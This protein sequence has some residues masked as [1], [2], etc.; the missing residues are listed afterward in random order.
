MLL[1]CLSVS[2]GRPH[3][4][5]GHIDFVP[6]VFPTAY[7]KTRKDEQSEKRYNRVKKRRF[8][9][10]LNPEAEETHKKGE[11]GEAGC[12]RTMEKEVMGATNIEASEENERGTQTCVSG[13]DL[14]D[15]ERE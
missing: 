3:A 6:S 1:N 12:S 2:I 5:S 10:A 15:R 13:C 7:K 9:K 4:D 11:C 14:E 8:N